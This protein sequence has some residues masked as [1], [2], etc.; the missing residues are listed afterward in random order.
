MVCIPLEGLQN[1]RII[2]GSGFE[3]PTSGLLRKLFI[4]MSPAGTPGCPTPLCVSYLSI[5][6]KITI[7]RG[8]FSFIIVLTIILAILLMYKTYTLTTQSTYNYIIEIQSMQNIYEIKLIMNRMIELI[9]IKFRDP[10]EGLILMKSIPITPSTERCYIN[11]GLTIALEQYEKYYEDMYKDYHLDLWCG[12]VSAND[13]K[14]MVDTG[15]KTAG[16]YDWSD[17]DIDPECERIGETE[18]TSICAQLIGIDRYNR[19]GKLQQTTSGK[20]AMI[21][22]YM[23]DPYTGIKTVD[24]IK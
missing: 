24:G 16:V 2:A 23:K 9:F 11:R 15:K 21:G 1:Q 12:H 20:I 5:N 10:P 14:E 6:I 13:I 17:K 22:Y 7:V 4:R 3:P 19:E 18:Y 8:L